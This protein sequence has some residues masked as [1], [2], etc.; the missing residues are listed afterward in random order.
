MTLAGLSFV[1]CARLCSNW[2]N[3]RAWQSIRT[4]CLTFAPR[5]KRTSR[6]WLLLTMLQNVVNIASALQL[7]SEKFSGIS[8][9]RLVTLI[10]NL[11][12]ATQRDALSG[13]G[14]FLYRTRSQLD[15]R[16]A[17]WR[18]TAIPC[19]H[20]HMRY[21][22]H[23]SFLLCVCDARRSAADYSTKTNTVP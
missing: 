3:S 22:T 4:T 1:L 12:Y 19:T 21:I 6:A 7:S 15:S 9:R 14:E 8:Q 13:V 17:C 18:P 11:P 23:L 5:R 16:S 20:A 2:L 10:I